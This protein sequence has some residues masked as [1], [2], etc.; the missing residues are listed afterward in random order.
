M[1]HHI[2]LSLAVEKNENPVPP[3]RVTKFVAGFS[4]HQCSLFQI[5]TEVLRSQVTSLHKNHENMHGQNNKLINS[6]WL[7][8]LKGHQSILSPYTCAFCLWEEYSTADNHMQ[9]SISLSL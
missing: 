7:G 3:N 2:N 8:I 9:L 1:N 4:F 5:P 6:V